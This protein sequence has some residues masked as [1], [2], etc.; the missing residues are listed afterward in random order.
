M[1]VGVLVTV[2]LTVLS[3]RFITSTSSDSEPSGTSLT[4]GTAHDVVTLTVSDPQTGTTGVDVELTPRDGV[5][6][7][8]SSTTVTVAAV[9]PTVGHA[10]PEYTATRT[11]GTTYHV[12]GL[13]LMMIGRWELLV[14]I[15]G[16]DGRH[17][18]LVVPLTLTS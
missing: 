15:S 13:P 3:L 4:S 7:P 12:A 2:L 6:A 8:D 14:D 16:N 1:A 9:L 10:V 18:Q 11:A 5:A 17:D